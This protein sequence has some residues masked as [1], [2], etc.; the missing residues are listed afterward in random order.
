[1]QNFSEFL[2]APDNADAVL[3]FLYSGLILTEQGLQIA[4]VPFLSLGFP[5][6]TLWAQ[7]H[8]QVFHHI[9]HVL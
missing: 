2:K 8:F 7:W 5:S 1:M 9:Y 3:L 4:Q 6:V